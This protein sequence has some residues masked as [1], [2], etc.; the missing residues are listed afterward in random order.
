MFAS[1]QNYLHTLSTDSKGRAAIHFSAEVHEFS[2]IV[3][4]IVETLQIY[5]SVHPEID[6]D[7]KHV[8]FG[9]MTKGANT[10]MAGFELALTGYFWEPQI[11]F[12]SA[13][14]GFATA[15][16][17]VNN[18]KRFA[19]WQAGKKFSSTDSISNLK[20]EIEPVGKMYGFLSEMYVHTSPINSSPP[21]FVSQGEAKFQFFGYL[22]P[23]KEDVRKGEVYVALLTSFVCLQ[24][25]E[26]IFHNYAKELETIEKIPGTDTVSTKVSARHRKFV[27][28]AMAHFST[29]SKDPSACF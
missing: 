28:A 26:I 8:A 13:L 7:P 12:R 3:S 24:L 14:E 2:T 1:V 11:L 22:P 20:K 17:I 4:K 6:A 5:H 27:D 15:W 18:P 29:R 9:L 25:T 10:L 19:V 16:D 23:D 21:M